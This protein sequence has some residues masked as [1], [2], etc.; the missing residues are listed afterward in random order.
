[1][2]QRD[3]ETPGAR[4]FT[5]SGDVYDRFMGRYSTRLAVPFADAAGIEPGQDVV[6]VGSGPGA[7][8]AE[9]VRRL[10]PE[11]V[12]AVDP[13]PQFVDAL[14]ARLPGV[15]AH[16]GRAEELPFPDA[17]F[18]AALAQLVLHFVS[19]ADATAREMRRV[20]RPGGVVGACVWDFG[21]GM[22]ML[23]LFWDAALAHD[24]DAPDEEHTRPFGRDGEIAELFER[25]G[26]RDVERGSLEVEA[27]YASFDDFWTP[28]L[29]TTGPA[30][31]YVHSLDEEK[32]VRLRDELRARLG[33]PDGPFTLA[34]SAWYATGR[35]P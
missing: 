21:G 4:T 22:R 9:L 12:A 34:A 18:D 20:V 35:V 32:R 15:D 27:S 5:V 10:G 29:S 3:G 23:R 25:A 28:L 19:D 33:S 8:S 7:L 31:Q 30:G 2:A 13:A 14:R 6:D 26:L 16:V 11:H 1:V 17:R 24:P